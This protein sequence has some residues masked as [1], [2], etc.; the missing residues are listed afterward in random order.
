MKSEN[1]L[2]EDV[3]HITMKYMELLQEN[4]VLSPAE[5]GDSRELISQIV[6]IAKEFEEMFPEET[7]IAEGNE[8]SLD[9]DVEIDKYAIKRLLELFS[10]YRELPEDDYMIDKSHIV[11]P[12]KFY[13]LL[14]EMMLQSG[15]DT[16]EEY[17]VL[18]TALQIR[19]AMQGDE[20]FEL[21]SLPV[22]SSV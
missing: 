2:Y 1:F 18:G 22:Q 7:W 20:N 17:Q 9:Y 16:E 19:R 10:R 14:V 12:K 4:K 21:D 11:L 6:A 15:L 13:G 3:I 8:C 5:L